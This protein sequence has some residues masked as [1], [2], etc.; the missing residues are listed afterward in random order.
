MRITTSMMANRSIYALNNS[1]RLMNKYQT[2]LETQSKIS[3]PSDDPVVAMKGVKNRTELS[4]ITQYIRNNNEANTWIDATDTAY[5]EAKSI[6][7]RMRELSNNLANGTNTEVDRKAA[8]EELKQLKKQMIE[9]ANTQVAG[10]YIFNG[11]DI[12]TKPFTENANGTVTFNS[13]AGADGVVRV[14]VS[15]ADGSDAMLDVNSM[16]TAFFVPSNSAGAQAT[17][18]GTTGVTA[19]GTMSVTI[20]NKS[21]TVE[22]TTADDSAEKVMKKINQ[23]SVGA[24]L[25]PVAELNATGEVVM[26]SYTN[27]PLGGGMAITYGGGLQIGGAGAPTP[28][29]SPYNPNATPPI[30][31]G[32]PQK[33]VFEEIDDL[34]T[35]VEGGGNLTEGEVSVGLSNWL[36]TADRMLERANL[37][38]AEVGGK[39]NRLELV[40]T[41]NKSTEV[42]VNKMLSENEE[43]RKSVV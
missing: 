40:E 23:A 11:T 5:D 18:T 17:L 10:Q 14:E 24:G 26:T 22:L 42:F 35:L 28:T 30:G 8:A 13:G 32:L 43:D 31:P 3:R 9:V 2:Q 6:I 1:Y 29:A 34:I 21:F 19:D 39:Q 25:G 7:H 36:Y 27:N 15:R 38:M 12:T 33:S 41:R 37:A 4:G 20:N 16:P